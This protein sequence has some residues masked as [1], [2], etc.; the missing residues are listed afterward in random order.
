MRVT[1]DRCSAP[2]GNGSEIDASPPDQTIDR[3]KAFIGGADPGRAP[4]G[5]ADKSRS[6]ES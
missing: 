1:I 5:L 2:V 4:I 6:D 3:R